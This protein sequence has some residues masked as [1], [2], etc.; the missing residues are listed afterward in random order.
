MCCLM[1]FVANQLAGDDNK[2]KDRLDFVWGYLQNQ[3]GLRL[4][5]TDRQLC[6]LARVLYTDY[7][8]A[9]QYKRKRFVCVYSVG[10]ILKR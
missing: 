6:W 1:S 10:S 7:L 2:C 9:I 8:I 5:G 4:V 3:S